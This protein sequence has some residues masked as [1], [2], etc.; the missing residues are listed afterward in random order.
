[1]LFTYHSFRKNSIKKDYNIY[2]Y[3]TNTQFCIKIYWILKCIKLHT[4]TYNYGLKLCLMITIS[5]VH[6]LRWQV[7]CFLLKVGCPKMLKLLG[8]GNLFLFVYHQ[9]H[10][11]PGTWDLLMACL[12]P[13]QR[14][15]FLVLC[16][17]NS[18][19]LLNYCACKNL[20]CFSVR[21]Q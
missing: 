16:K 14:L 8:N 5:K 20:P 18:Y 2:S 11:V 7:S 17:L 10:L 3:Q 6:L 15:L 12:V 4:K 21:Y 19:F 13:K 9:A 1:M